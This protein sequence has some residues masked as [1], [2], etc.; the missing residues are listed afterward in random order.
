MNGTHRTPRANKMLSGGK[1]EFPFQHGKKG[2]NVHLL[3]HI[4]LEAT[5][6]TILYMKNPKKS[7]KKLI[8]VK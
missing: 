6:V 8:K 1:V 4:L 7:T 3:F 5:Y 2:K